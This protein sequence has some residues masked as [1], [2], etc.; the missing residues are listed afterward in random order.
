MA[1]GLEISDLESLDRLDYLCSENKG[2]DQLGST[3]QLTCALVFAYAKSKFSHS[4]AQMVSPNPDRA[5]E[6]Q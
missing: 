4:A 2:A 1:A 5:P 6:L 3:V